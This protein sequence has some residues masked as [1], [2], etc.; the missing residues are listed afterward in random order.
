MRKGPPLFLFF[1]KPWPFVGFVLGWG[2]LSLDSDFDLV[3][4][5][6]IQTP[7]GQEGWP[8]PFTDICTKRVA[9][10]GAGDAGSSRLVH[11]GAGQGLG[12][13]AGEGARQLGCVSL[14]ETWS[15]PPRNAGPES[16]RRLLWK[17]IPGSG[18]IGAPW[19]AGPSGDLGPECRE[20]RAGLTSKASGAGSP[21]ASLP[22]RSSR[23]A[24]SQA[25][26]PS[27]PALSA[28]PISLAPL[29]LCLSPWLHSVV[30]VDFLLSS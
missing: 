25:A 9:G 11:L 21:E 15:L 29:P 6:T 16:E 2:N 28:S 8:K 20:L 12:G 13:S 14:L 1:P 3:V 4:P 17:P 26:F 18:R 24:L 10:A 27:S 23:Q 30:C 19:A 5:A 7:R 22:P